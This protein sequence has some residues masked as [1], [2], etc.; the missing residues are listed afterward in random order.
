MAVTSITITQSNVSGNINLLAVHNPLVFIVDV[1]YTSTPPD[2]IYAELQDNESNVL[3]TFR[4]IPYNDDSDLNIRTFVFIASDII[5]AY[6]DDIDDFESLT[7]TLEHVENI[8][9]EFTLRFYNGLIENSISF[10]ACH[11]A[12]QYGDTPYLESIYNNDNETYYGAVGMP[13]Y[14]YFYNNDSDNV[15]SINT[16]TADN[17]TALDYDDTVFVDFDDYYFKIS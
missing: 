3:S 7:G 17:E 16:P 2:L 9:K 5:K 8:T 13:V 10:V 12:R 6:M 15:L 4:A 14:V 1:E 11:A